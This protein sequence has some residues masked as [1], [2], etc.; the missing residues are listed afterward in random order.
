MSQTSHSK[1]EVDSG[2]IKQNRTLVI[3]SHKRARFAHG[4]YEILIY[5]YKLAIS[6]SSRSNS[7]TCEDMNRQIAENYQKKL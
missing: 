2:A 3:F 4:Y 7:K 6:S 5:F 1:S